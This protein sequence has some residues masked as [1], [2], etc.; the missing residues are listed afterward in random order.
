[1]SITTWLVAA[2]VA[3]MASSAAGNGAY[4]LYRSSAA[5]SEARVYVATFNASNLDNQ[6]NCEIARELF[7]S[8]PGVV[9]IYWC[10]D[11][12]TSAMLDRQWVDDG[13]PVL[14]RPLQASP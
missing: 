9:V 10:E 8:Q 11:A 14:S 4:R 13:K 1:M 12:S 2:M 7:Q 6:E 3:L 5:I